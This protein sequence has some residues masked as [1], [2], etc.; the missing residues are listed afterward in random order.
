MA[1]I[2]ID[3]EKGVAR[4]CKQCSGRIDEVRLNSH[5]RNLRDLDAFDFYV[6]TDCVTVKNNTCRYC[7]GAVYIPRQRTAEEEDPTI[8]PACRNDVI[9]DTGNDPGWNPSD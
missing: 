8:C 1:D 5:L 9:T 3:L 2:D 6:C 4:V 7:S